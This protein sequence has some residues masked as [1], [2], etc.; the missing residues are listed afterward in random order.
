MRKLL[1]TAIALIVLVDAIAA[2]CA[3]C[4]GAS[5]ACQLPKI[6]VCTALVGKSC[7]PTFNL[8]KTP[9]YFLGK[10]HAQ[11][12]KKAAK[13]AGAPIN[14]SASAYETPSICVA[15]GVC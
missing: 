2:Q 12:A 4:L 13:A 8:C 7:P 11:A 10:L 1:V 14:V 9:Q 15:L 6:N 5:G 3:N